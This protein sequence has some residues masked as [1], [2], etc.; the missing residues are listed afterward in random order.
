MNKIKEYIRDNK[1]NIIITAIVFTAFFLI[2]NIQFI[3]SHGVAPDVLFFGTEHYKAGN[4]E[5]S[6]G[7]FG[8]VLIDKLKF[9]LVNKQIIMAYCMLYLGISTLL[10]QN[11]FNIKRKISVILLSIVLAVFPTFTET[12]FFLYCADS[13]CLAFLLSVIAVIG[14]KKYIKTDKIKY[15]S[16]AIISTVMTCS[17]Y[18]AYLGLIFG[19]YAIYIITNKKDINIKV[20]LKT[21]LILCL[22]VI[23][24]Y[25]LVNC[26]LAIKGIKL[27]TYKGANSLGIETI[28]QIPKSVI[29]TYYDIANFLFGNKVIYNNIYYRRIINSVMVLSIILLIR[30]SKEYTI[31]SIITRSIFIGILPICIAIMDI[32]A[33]TTTINLVTGP[34]LITIYILI[35]TLLDKYKFSSK[36]QKILEI[37]IVTMIVI[38]MHTFIIQNNYTYRVR[39]HTYQNFYTIQNNIYTRGTSLK[40]YKKEMKWLFS[41][42]IPFYSEYRKFGNGFI[43][44]DNETYIGIRRSSNTQIMNFYKNYMGIN[45]SICSTDEYDQIVNT[46]EFKEMQSYPNDNSIRIINNCVVV[47]IK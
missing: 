5:I 1:T 15:A 34:G 3:F 9:G 43:S 13:Y 2:N 16:I 22:S 27:A 7:R 4:W 6:L 38:T 10:I 41:D 17:L 47:K 29:H 18:Q 44:N 14:I 25:A 11:L 42:T 33:P 8:L 39:E 32:I 36:I 26:I 40:G 24:Y 35:I 28:K 19:L 21:I 20:I 45:I 12:Y 30:K 23:I 31:K 46:E 37:L